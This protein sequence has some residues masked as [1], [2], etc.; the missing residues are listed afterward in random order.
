MR[1]SGKLLVWRDK[2]SHKLSNRQNTSHFWILRS[3]NHHNWGHTKDI[4]DMPRTGRP[5]ELSNRDKSGIFRM[6]RENP[7]LSYK[8]LAQIFESKNNLKVSRELVR[9][10]LLD[11]SI[12]PYIAARKPILSITDKH[13]Q[14]VWS[15]ERLDWSVELWAK[16][17]WSDEANFQVVIHKGRIYVKRFATD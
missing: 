2:K 5:S 16:V 1:S 9:W 15:K 4:S 7:R 8:K 10:T 12:G 13:K 14:Q 11:K 6:S 3:K 17:I